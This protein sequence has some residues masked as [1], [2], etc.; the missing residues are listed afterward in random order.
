[1]RAQVISKVLKL[2][3]KFHYNAELVRDEIRTLS[4]ELDSVWICHEASKPPLASSPTRD[5]VIVSHNQEIA[6]PGLRP[7]NTSID[8]E[9]NQPDAFDSAALLREPH[10]R[11]LYEV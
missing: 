9:P 4:A 8:E 1:L 6:Q 7:T 10:N 2:L 11:E 5:Q 3:D